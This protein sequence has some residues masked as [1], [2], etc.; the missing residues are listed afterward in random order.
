MFPSLFDPPVF[1]FPWQFL[2]FYF[3]FSFDVAFFGVLVL[4]VLVLGSAGLLGL[5]PFSDFPLHLDPLLVALDGWPTH[6]WHEDMFCALSL[7]LV[8]LSQYVPCGAFSAWLVV[9]QR[10]QGCWNG[11]LLILL[12]LLS[13]HLHWLFLTFSFEIIP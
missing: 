12:P 9:F 5:L 8:S 10:F 11:S 1:T 4:R 3:V 2:P 13:L 7:V 6:P